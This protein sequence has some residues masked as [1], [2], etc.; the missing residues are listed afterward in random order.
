MKMTKS[1]APVK[2]YSSKS[3]GLSDKKLGIKAGSK[4]DLLLDSKR[5]ISS[6][7]KKGAKKKVVAKKTAPSKGF[8]LFAKKK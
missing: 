1:N 8:P 3:D 2:K 4:K 6:A 5:G 7:T